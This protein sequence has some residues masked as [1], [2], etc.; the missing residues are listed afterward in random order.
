MTVAW[1][2]GTTWSCAR[3][4]AA[5]GL[6]TGSAPK[7]SQALEQAAQG[8]GHSPKLLELKKCLD[9]AVRHRV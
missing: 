1:P 2:E 3:R 6:G 4:G 5:G 8:N 7:G 9:S